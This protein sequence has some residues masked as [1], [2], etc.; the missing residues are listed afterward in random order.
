[1]LSLVIKIPDNPTNGDMWLA[2]YGG[3]VID[4][5]NGKVYVEKAYFPFNLEWWSAPFKGEKDGKN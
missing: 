3:M 5:K 2:V 1:M 4:I